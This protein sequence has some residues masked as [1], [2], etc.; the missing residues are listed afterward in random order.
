MQQITPHTAA[1]YLFLEHMSK[2]SKIKVLKT[3]HTNAI[4]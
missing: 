1:I 4:K 2:E 3:K